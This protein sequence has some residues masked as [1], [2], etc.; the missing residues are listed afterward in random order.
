MIAGCVLTLLALL[1]FTTDFFR[2]PSAIMRD[3][4]SQLGDPGQR[5]VSIRIVLEPPANVKNASRPSLTGEGTLIREKG[6]QT[7]LDMLFDVRLRRR[8]T[9]LIY[10]ILLRMVRGGI[11]WQFQELPGTEAT[12]EI[13]KNKWLRLADEQKDS[14]QELPDRERAALARDLFSST[15][16]RKI[17]RQGRESVAGF[18]ARKYRIVVNDERLPDVLK[19]IA[20]RS[21]HAGVRG[22]ALR[23]AGLLKNFRIETLEVWVAPRSHK[24]LQL[25]LVLLQRAE[26]TESQPRLDGTLTLLPLKN[27]SPVVP[28]EKSARFRRPD[29]LFRLIG[30]GLALPIRSP[31]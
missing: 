22:A 12:A 11:Y 31:Q 26:N 14:S 5:R 6:Q 10:G 28:P 20:E 15:V 3:A 1:A 30:A 13:I 19:E 21:Q 16:V 27:P 25:H 8:G 9:E 2:S 23:S 24:L 4:F 7:A 17:E 18:S 29:L